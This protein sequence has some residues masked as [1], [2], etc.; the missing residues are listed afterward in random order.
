MCVCVA[1]PVVKRRGVESLV[2]HVYRLAIVL[3]VVPSYA[4]G[5]CLLTVIYCVVMCFFLYLFIDLKNK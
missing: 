2:L 4:N 1:E 5:Y 3:V